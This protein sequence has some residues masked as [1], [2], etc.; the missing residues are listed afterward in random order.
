[1]QKSAT[2]VFCI[3]VSDSLYISYY[4]NTT[5][6]KSLSQNACALKDK[7][8]WKQCL[9]MQFHNTFVYTLQ[10]LCN[11]INFAYFVNTVRIKTCV[12][13]VLHYSYRLYR[14]ATLLSSTQGYFPFY[15]PFCVSPFPWVVVM[16]KVAARAR[17]L[18]EGGDCGKFCVVPA[19][20]WPD[21]FIICDCFLLN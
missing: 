15:C 12:K 19:H 1:M 21:T 2:T 10:Y 17:P 20:C 18:P 14:G 5:L 8:T 3:F 9:T 6:K 11:S 13:E 16:F 7:T 4:A